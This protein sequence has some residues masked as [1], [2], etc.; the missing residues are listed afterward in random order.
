MNKHEI[1]LAAD[2]AISKGEKFISTAK[3]MITCC[4]IFL[5]AV[6]ALK[7]VLSKEE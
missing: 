6:C 2:T 3:D 4:E 7:E 5:T 1:I